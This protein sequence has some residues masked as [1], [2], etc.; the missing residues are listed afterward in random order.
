MPSVS[1]NGIKLEYEV[2]GNRNA[3]AMVLI[4]GLGNQLTAWPELF[5]E[6]LADRGFYVIRFDNRDVGLSTLFTDQKV[7]NILTLSLLSRIGIKQSVPYGLK[8]MALDTV[9]LID[10]L[11]I[12]SAHIVGISMGGMIAQIVAAEHKKHVK[13]LTCIISTS[14][15]PRMPGP[16]KEVIKKILQKPKNRDK[17]TWIKYYYELFRLIGSPE[18][19]AE[20]LMQKVRERVERSFYPEGTARQYAA[21]MHNGSRIEQLN[22]IEAPT[23]AISGALDPMVPYEG[24]RDIAANVSN[25]R[26]ELIENLGHDLPDSI[27]PKVVDLVAAHARAVE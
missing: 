2:N 21:I 5:Y 13:T 8:D 25:A 24:G 23:L 18:M 4:M 17:E 6:M 19:D 22:Q 20:V 15:N 10:A 27:I 11:G 16:T 7:P 3:P 9:A 12:D 26:F 14:G 1:A